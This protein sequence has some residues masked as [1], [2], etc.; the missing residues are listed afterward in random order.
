LGPLDFA[1]FKRRFRVLGEIV[2]QLRIEI[3]KLDTEGPALLV[4][5]ECGETFHRYLIELIGV[6]FAQESRVAD[7]GIFAIAPGAAY[8][9]P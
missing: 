4:A 9:Q 6:E 1:V 5:P 2:G 3:R 7:L 8:F